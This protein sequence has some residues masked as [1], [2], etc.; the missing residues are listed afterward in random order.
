MNFGASQSHGDWKLPM[1]IPNAF[2]DVIAE[3]RSQ[4]AK[5]GEQNHVSVPPCSS[6]DAACELLGIPTED[7]CK[8][9]TDEYASGRHL[10]W[11]DVLLEEFAEAVAAPNEA[12]RRAELVQVA[13]VA[14]AWI[15]CID[16][17]AVAEV[18]A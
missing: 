9:R 8:Q 1:P 12:L 3:R 2:A 10:T 17:R 13:A 14:I 4:N 7:D 15:E 5:W 16:R 11:A 18:K 6:G